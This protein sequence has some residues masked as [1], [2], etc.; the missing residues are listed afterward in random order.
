[1]NLSNAIGYSNSAC[2]NVY[3][4]DWIALPHL[5]GLMVIKV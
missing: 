3:V 5:F 2:V 4:V 1:M